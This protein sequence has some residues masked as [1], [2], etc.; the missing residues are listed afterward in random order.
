[1]WWASL[2]CWWEGRG[3]KEE[4]KNRHT[5]KAVLSCSCQTRNKFVG[6]MA[7]KLTDTK[8]DGKKDVIGKLFSTYWTQAQQNP[9]VKDL[10]LLKVLNFLLVV[11]SG[12][13]I[14]CVV[15]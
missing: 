13:K 12:V 7:D 5:R 4:L 11:S 3:W 1:M 2:D 14:F 10:R 9:G 15:L 8:S 6:I